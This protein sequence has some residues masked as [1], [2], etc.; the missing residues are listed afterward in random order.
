MARPIGNK[1]PTS[2]AR[3]D[4]S[5][6]PPHTIAPATPA[7]VTRAHAQPLWGVED[8]CRF[9]G[10]SKR[11]LHER[12]R[13]GEIPCYRFGAALRFDPQEVTCWAANFHHPPVATETGT[14]TSR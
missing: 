2:V 4:A 1:M 9:L 11:W 3:K 14:G 5:M 12:T 6:R 7:A 13:L 8:V 10:F